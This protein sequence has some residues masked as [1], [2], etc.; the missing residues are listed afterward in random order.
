M[1]VVGPKEAENGTV[2]MRH[3]SKGDLGARSIADMVSALKQESDSR[4]I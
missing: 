1:L 2:S 4:A 3:R